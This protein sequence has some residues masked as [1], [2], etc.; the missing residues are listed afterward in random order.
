MNYLVI[1]LDFF[2]LLFVCLCAVCMQDWKQVIMMSDLKVFGVFL[3][4]R[5]VFLSL[6]REKCV[7]VTE[8]RLWNKD[9]NT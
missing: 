3:P 7:S 5:V 2:Y 9:A 4:D 6:L 8:T 1:H